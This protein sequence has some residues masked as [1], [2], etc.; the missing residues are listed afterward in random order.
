MGMGIQLFGALIP[1]ETRY[2]IYEMTATEEQM[3]DETW[4]MFWTSK[5]GFRKLA[6][7]LLQIDIEG[8]TDKQ[9]K[10]TALP[11]VVSLERDLLKIYNEGLNKLKKV[12]PDELKSIDYSHMQQYRETFFK[13]IKD[14][15]KMQERVAL[16]FINS[17][18]GT[19]SDFTE[20]FIHEKGG[21]ISNT[22][23]RSIKWNALS[24]QEKVN[25]IYRYSYMKN[26]INEKAKERAA[27]RKR[28]AKRSAEVQKKQNENGKPAIMPLKINRKA[29][30]SM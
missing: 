3:V 28:A 24:A 21:D 15:P 4:K 22:V 9:Y 14:E 20:W 7:E 11:K 17:M 27:N 10:Q 18:R 29:I 8:E 19:T 13:T 12:R 26:L 16:A 1:K 30:G 2:K 23:K 5:S 6:V 25:W